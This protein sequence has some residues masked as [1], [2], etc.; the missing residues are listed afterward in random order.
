MAKFNPKDP[1]ASDIF[2]GLI[3]TAAAVFTYRLV[4]G[5]MYHYTPHCEEILEHLKAIVEITEEYD[6]TKIEV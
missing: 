1:K 2:C 3:N 6:R 4:L 5:G